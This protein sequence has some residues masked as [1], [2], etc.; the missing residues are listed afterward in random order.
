MKLLLKTGLFS[1]SATLCFATANAAN[2]VGL[3]TLNSL[4]TFDSGSPE[5]LLS[6]RFVTGLSVNEQLLAIDYR[7]QTGTLYGLGSFGQLYTL[8]VMTGSATFVA[9]LTDSINFNQVFLNGTE[10]DADFNP[11]VDRIRITSNLGQNLRVNPG[12]GV[13]IQDGSLNGATFPH[14]VAG[15]YTNNDNDPLT[16]TTLFTID[17]NSDRLNM[18]LP[19]NAGTQVDV[20]ALGGDYTALA[21]FDIFT[22]GTNNFAFAALQSNGTQGSGFYTV[23]L[24]SGAAT[25]IGGIGSNQTGDVLAIRDIA[26][27]PVPEPASIAIVGVGAAALLRRRT[28]AKRSV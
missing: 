18:Q 2:V 1:A 16:G 12:T 3:S 20:G 25:K 10:F 9:G 6:A 27:T 17:S 11:T 8:N 14:I 22:L 19:P 24:V 26:I 7:P 21:G 28:L 4:V 23:N 13:A 15:A 5:T